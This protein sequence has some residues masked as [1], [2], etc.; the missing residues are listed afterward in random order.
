[1]ERQNAAD[2]ALPATATVQDCDRC[3]EI[4]TH[5]GIGS[6]TVCGVFAG[7]ADRRIDEW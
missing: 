6:E 4:S 2:P 1:M 3:G 7:P 5:A